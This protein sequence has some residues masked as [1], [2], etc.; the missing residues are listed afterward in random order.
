MKHLGF[1]WRLVRRGMRSD[2][3]SCDDS[4]TTTLACAQPEATSP[5]RPI[6]MTPRPWC[7]LVTG[8]GQGLDNNCDGLITGDEEAGCPGDFDSDGA[9]SV[10]TCWSTSKF[11][12]EVNFLNFDS[13]SLV[14]I[15]DLTG[16]LSVFEM[17]A[18]LSSSDRLGLLLNHRCKAHQPE[19]VHSVSRLQPP[20]RHPAT[21][22]SAPGC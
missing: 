19:Q 10:A 8:T 13:D 17:N 16:F 2:G 20:D 7:F 14:N 15:E 6:A 22:W 4:T 9:I 5:M 11:G 18:E 1:R 12:C 21:T 3:D